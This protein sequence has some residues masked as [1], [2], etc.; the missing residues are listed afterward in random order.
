MTLSDEDPEP[1]K[2]PEATTKPYDE[3]PRPSSTGTSPFVHPLVHDPTV[4]RYRSDG[5]I[6]RSYRS[7]EHVLQHPACVTH[8]YLRRLV[9]H[10]QEPWAQRCVELIVRHPAYANLANTKSLKKEWV[11]GV[12]MVERVEGFVRQL[13]LSENDHLPTVDNHGN[14]MVLLDLCSGKGIAALLLALRFPQATVLAVDLRPPNPSEKH[15]QL[16]VGADSTDTYDDECNH[17]NL[18][19]PRNLIRE[20]ANVYDTAR[21]QDLL[22]QHAEQRHIMVVGTHLCGDLS[23]AALDFVV[24]NNGIVAAAL[25]PCCLPRQKAP[26]GR[27]HF[28]GKDFG[29]DTTFVARRMGINPHHLWMQRLAQRAATATAWRSTVWHDEDL[30]VPSRSKAAPARPMQHTPNVYLLLIKREQGGASD[31]WTTED[32]HPEWFCQPIVSASN[33]NS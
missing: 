20:T 26:A 2:E 17:R 23:R 27:V 6:R 13:R 24:E 9:H 14:G 8:R 21:L 25:V 19:P 32:S 4:I 31:I 29:Y 22:Q 7:V 33:Y 3:R 15:L 12:S 1:G 18:C 16:D 10:P 30:V 28:S 11:E 5:T